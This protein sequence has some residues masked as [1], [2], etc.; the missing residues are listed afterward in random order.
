VNGPLRNVPMVLGAV[1]ETTIL[2]SGF[3]ALFILSLNHSSEE[4][5]IN[6]RENMKNLN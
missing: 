5:N 3:E 1:N 4:K 6:I 2:F